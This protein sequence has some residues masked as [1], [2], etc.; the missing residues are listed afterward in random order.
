MDYSKSNHNK[1]TSKIDNTRSNTFTNDY[2]PLKIKESK[3]KEKRLNYNIYKN[4]L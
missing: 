4:E 3:N 2:S 1:T